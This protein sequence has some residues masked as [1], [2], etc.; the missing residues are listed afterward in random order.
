MP[1]QTHTAQVLKGAYGDYS[2]ANAADYTYL[3]A[4]VANKE[5]T[6]LTGQEILLVRN[7]DGAGAHNITITSVDDTFN[8]SENVT[9]YSLGLNEFAMFGPF[10]LTGWIQTDG[11]LYFEADNVNIEFAVVRI[12]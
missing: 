4:D 11:N 2:V 5:Q 10:K 9:N 8:R 6:K 7:V 12:P 1:R 3:A